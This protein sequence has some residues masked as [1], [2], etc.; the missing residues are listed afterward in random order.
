M[1]LRASPAV[2]L[3]ALVPAASSGQTPPPPGGAHTRAMVF[4]S[5]RGT[6][7]RADKELSGIVIK[8]DA[9]DQMAWRFRPRVVEEAARFPPGTP[10]WVIYR[11]MAPGQRAVTAIGFPDVAPR[12]L[13]VNATGDP[14]R[15]RTAAAAGGECASLTA[16]GP[17]A[18]HGLGRNG[19]VEDDGACWC[20]AGPT[21]TCAPVNRSGA[22]R[23]VLSQCFP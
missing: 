9:G 14:V 19:S 7:V 6:L 12:P 4:Q 2:L 20:C 16:E 13:Y 23:I 15:L 1:G 22:G 8:T 5:V 21:E 17:A 3:L 11:E 10:L 18:E